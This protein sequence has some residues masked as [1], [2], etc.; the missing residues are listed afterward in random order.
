MLLKPSENLKFSWVSVLFAF[1]FCLVLL[2]VCS[3][4]QFLRI[5]RVTCQLIWRRS[6]N[7]WG[8]L[9][10]RLRSQVYEGVR[11]FTQEMQCHSH[12]PSPARVAVAS[13]L[14]LAY[15]FYFA[16]CLLS[17]SPKICLIFVRTRKSFYYVN[18]IRKMSF[19]VV[20]VLDSSTS[21]RVSFDLEGM[22]VSYIGVSYQSPRPKLSQV[23]LGFICIYGSVVQP[24]EVQRIQSRRSFK[25]FTPLIFGRL[26]SDTCY[27]IGDIVGFCQICPFSDPGYSHMA[28]L[29]IP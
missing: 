2:S 3:L 28:E 15:R 8:G 9:F 16:V 5:I 7:L 11:V 10:N 25:A 17:S 12:S 18:R 20:F 22:C 23:V 26:P 4:D 24:A 27:K 19:N 29:A 21:S 14:M 13:L 6:I 1:G